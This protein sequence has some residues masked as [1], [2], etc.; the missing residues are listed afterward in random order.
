M[1]VTPLT[2]ALLAHLRLPIDGVTPPDAV[3][4]QDMI[5]QG[6]DIEATD[7]DG[8][9]PLLRCL[10]YQYPASNRGGMQTAIQ[11]TLSALLQA[12]ADITAMTPQGDS[13]ID[14]AARW[15][16]STLATDMLAAETY[17]RSNPAVM[18]AFKYIGHDWPKPDQ[19]VTSELKLKFL[20]ACHIGDVDQ[21]AYTLHFYPGAV[22]WHDDGWQ[23]GLSNPLTTAII[24]SNHREKVADLLIAAGCDVNWQDRQGMT[25]LHSLCTSQ[26]DRT[27]LYIPKLIVAGARTDLRNENGYTPREL[28]EHNQLPMIVSILDTAVDTFEK[29]QAILHSH[30]SAQVQQSRTDTL[31]HRRAS[32]GGKFKFKL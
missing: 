6:A 14:L 21:V 26:S 17:R 22:D 13:A 27:A 28:A 3:Y 32:D 29:L 8:L 12:G 18:A 25:A 23:S 31:T 24:Q 2:T 11:S 4:V 20:N 10:S 30:H 16:G 1:T 15:S 19:P 9:T 5:S 7:E